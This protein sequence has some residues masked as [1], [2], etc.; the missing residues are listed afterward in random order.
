MEDR[1]TISKYQRIGGWIGALVVGGVFLLVSC[2]QPLDG[3]PGYKLVTQEDPSIL[4]GFA[5]SF[6]VGAVVG[7]FPGIL[8][9][10]RYGRKVAA[11]QGPAAR[12]PTPQPA[13]IPAFKTLTPQMV[14]SYDSGHIE[15]EFGSL[16][17]DLIFQRTEESISKGEPLNQEA[18]AQYAT[19]TAAAVMMAK[20]HLSM[21]EMVK[22]VER[23]M[24]RQQGR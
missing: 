17:T 12:V 5:L 8:L 14:A 7:S 16:F 11:R 13:E 4:W 21:G 3:V 2:L 24:S 9:G 15:E 6:V 23:Y 20:Y 22:I 18:L 1:R 19:N 10:A